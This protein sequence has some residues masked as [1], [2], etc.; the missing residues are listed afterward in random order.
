MLMNLHV[1]YLIVFV[2]VL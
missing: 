2:V 1:Y